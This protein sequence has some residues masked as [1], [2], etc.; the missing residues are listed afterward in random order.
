MD[1]PVNPYPQGLYNPQHEH[2]SCG[3]GFIAHLKAQKSHQTS[4]SPEASIGRWRHDLDPRIQE[5]CN[6]QLG[7]LLSEFA[8]ATAGEDPRADLIQRARSE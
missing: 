5:A 3:V 8:T 1:R 4:S 7:D 2:D 6:H